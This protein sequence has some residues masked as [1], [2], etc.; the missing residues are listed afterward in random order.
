MD[1]LPPREGS[2]VTARADFIVATAFNLRERA[3]AG[4][5]M[6]PA[7]DSITPAQAASL[8]RRVRCECCTWLEKHGGSPAD[9]ITPRDC[10]AA[11]AFCIL[12][13]D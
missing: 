13:H 4:A 10:V 11:Y 1:L 5:G 2:M 6:L 8:P 12:Q 7:H 3:L 9:G